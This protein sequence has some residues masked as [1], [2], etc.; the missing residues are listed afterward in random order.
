ML[1]DHLSLVEERDERLVR[2]LNQ[3]ELKR[4]IVE[5]DAL[6]GLENRAQCSAAGNYKTVIMR[7][8]ARF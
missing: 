4:I 7:R 6:K 8:G 3:H 5:G 1:L 2:R